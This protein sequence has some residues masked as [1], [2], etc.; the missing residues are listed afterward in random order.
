MANAYD[1]DDA[2]EAEV[3]AER[4]L[5]VAKLVKEV[6]AAKKKWA[7]VFK[8]MRKCM[9]FAEGQHYKTVVV[10]DER[11][12]VDVIQRHINSRTAALYMRN[13]TIVVKRK[14]RLDFA[15]WDGKRESLEKLYMVAQQGV[16]SPQDEALMQDIINGLGRKKMMDKFGATVQLLVTHSLDAQ[17]PSFKTQA[18]Q[19]VPRV[20]TCGVGY[21]RSGYQRE[22]QKRPDTQA[23]LFDATDR[24][25]VLTRLEKKTKDG[26]I[27][28]E[29][30]AAKIIRDALSAEENVVVRE[31]VVYTFPKATAII[32]DTKLKQLDNFLGCDWVVEEHMMTCDDIEEFSGVKVK[33]SNRMATEDGTRAKKAN[34]DDADTVYPVWEMFH[35]KHGVVYWL[36]EGHD[37]FLKPPVAPD[38]FFEGF[39]NHEPIVFNRQ[40]TECNPFPRSDVELLMPMQKEINRT[41]EALRQH[42]IASRPV[43]VSRTGL[44]EKNDKKTLSQYDAH[45]IIELNIGQSEDV[46]KVITELKKTNIDQNVYALDPVFDA[47]NRVAGTSEANLGG[48]SNAT[49]TE[50]SISEASRISSLASNTDDMDDL[51][52]RVAQNT[53]VIHMLETDEENVI[54][55]VGPGAVW[56]QFPMSEILDELAI[57]IRGGSSGRPNRDREMAIMERA[58]P[59]ILQLPGVKPEPVIKRF[60]EILDDSLEIEEFYDPALPSMTAMNAQKQI[61][62]GDPA[63]D[64]NAQGPQGGGNAPAQIGSRPGPQAAFPT[65]APPL[66]NIPTD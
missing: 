25:A 62:T 58:T 11:L 19:L 51:L 18:K 36:C 17:I 16:A 5:L 55:I 65:S 30:E 61:G 9:K 15:L 42:R 45:E 37:D 23:K 31:G 28:A 66:D 26:R 4:K 2:Y 10:D 12:Q 60:L 50:S 39:W 14:R 43:Y 59:L 3:S 35:K 46:N 64:P 40:E 63:T 34:E 53:S 47:I 29:L 38:V 24:I 54:R 52:S 49:A 33:P 1:F 56:P 21:I 22:L 32:P 7:P 20:L 27:T 8:K 44:L 6:N 57:G 48:T 13:P 41:M